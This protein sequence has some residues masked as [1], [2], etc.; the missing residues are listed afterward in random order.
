MRNQDMGIFQFKEVIEMDRQKIMIERMPYNEW[1]TIREIYN[2]FA[3]DLYTSS[4]GLRNVLSRLVKYGIL[5]DKLE[6]DIIDKHEKYFYRR[7][8]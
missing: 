6:Y 3:T 1:F 8:W 5:E 7:I 2:N 4:H